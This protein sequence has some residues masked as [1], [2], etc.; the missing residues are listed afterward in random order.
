MFHFRAVS[1]GVEKGIFNVAYHEGIRDHPSDDSIAPD[2]VLQV[3]LL[4][5]RFGIS[6][7]EVGAI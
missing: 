1:E 6:V 3:I 4:Q 2:A 7:I 5:E